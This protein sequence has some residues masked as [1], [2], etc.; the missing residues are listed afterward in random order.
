MPGTEVL[1]VTDDS[2]TQAPSG[3]KARSCDVYEGNFREVRGF[4]VRL[5][6]RWGTDLLVLSRLYGLIDAEDIIKPYGPNEADKMVL[7][8]GIRALTKDLERPWNVLVLLLK[9]EGLTRLLSHRVPAPSP[10][11]LIFV[12][13][14]PF[15]VPVQRFFRIPDIRYYP[16]KRVG[17]ARIGRR[18]QEAILSILDVVLGRSGRS[19]AAL[20][21]AAGPWV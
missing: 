2:L 16:F 17:V 1:I 9:A 13:A 3:G 21:E 18:H 14:D 4:Y 8:R 11:H 20:Q 7:E 15:T 12:G 19:R 6:R 5:S 10:G